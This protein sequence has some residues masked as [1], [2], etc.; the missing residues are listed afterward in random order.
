MFSCKVFNSQSVTH[1]G[2]AP[3]WGDPLHIADAISKTHRD[4]N[5]QSNRNKTPLVL[6]WVVGKKDADIWSLV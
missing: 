3:L 6:Q 2:V 5:P 1:P 4:I